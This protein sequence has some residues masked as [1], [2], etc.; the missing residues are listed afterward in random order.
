MK[1]SAQKAGKKAKCTKCEAIVLIQ[2]D[3]ELDKPEPVAEAPPPP[4]KPPEDDEFSATGSY[5]VF[6]DPEV[7]ERQRILREEEEAAGKKRKDR[8]KLPSVGRKIKAIPD[9]KAWSTVRVGMLFVFFSVWIWLGCHLLQGSYALLGT[10]EFS[11]FGR[12]MARNIEFRNND[13]FPEMGQGWDLDWMQ[14]YLG[15]VAGNHFLGYAHLCITIASVLYFFQAILCL[16]GYGCCLPVP[17]RYGMFGHVI[18]LM[19]LGAFNLLFMLIFKILPVLGVHGYVLIPFVTPEIVLTEYNM[20]RTVPIHI[21]WSAAPFWENVLNLI[22][23]FMFYLEPTFLSIFVWS[24]GIL[25]KDENIE[26]GGRGRTLMSLGTFFILVTFHLLSLCGSS[27]VLIVVLRV[28]YIVWYFFLII[29][30]LQY[31]MLLLKFRAV[32]YDKIHPKFE[33]EGEEKD[34]D[35]GEDDEDEEDEDDRPRKKK[36][37]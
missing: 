2:A 26:Q 23:K 31:A 6:T 3:G 19:I 16:L 11:E 27:T 35:E 25:I 5:D 29:F 20:E 28:I 10:V 37:R 7:A 4:A 1:F 33:L 9:A 34:E 15:M 18:I 30:M 32:L 36:K 22:L 24:A 12:M 17:R 13:G 14:I 21:L 8:K